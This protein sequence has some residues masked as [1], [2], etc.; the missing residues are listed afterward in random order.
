M[1]VKKEK[2]TVHPGM[3]F[4]RDFN[5]KPVSLYEP[6]EETQIITVQGQI[7]GMDAIHTKTGKYIVCFN[8]TDFQTAYW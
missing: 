1:K 5:D 6:M 4:G 3:L 7:F 2:I 8:L